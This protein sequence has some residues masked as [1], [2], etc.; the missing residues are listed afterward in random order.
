MPPRAIDIFACRTLRTTSPGDNGRDA[1]GVIVTPDSPVLRRIYPS[2][3]P[4]PVRRLD[5][6]AAR[7]PVPGAPLVGRERELAN[8]CALLAEP[9]VRLLTLTGPGGV[10]KTRL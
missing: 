5:L 8:L 9:A 1:E 10:G 2:L 4:M 7:L 3:V 6:A